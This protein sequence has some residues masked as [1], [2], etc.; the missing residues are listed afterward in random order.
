MRSRSRPS[1]VEIHTI[2]S[3]VGFTPNIPT[4]INSSRDVAKL[5]KHLG[6]IKAML[7]AITASWC[8]ACHQISDKLNKILND[9]NNV[10]PA[11]RLDY[12]NLP[13]LNKIMKTP[14]GADAYP[15][16]SISDNQGNSLYKPKTVEEAG[17]IIS[18]R[19]PIPSM[20]QSV[21][22]PEQEAAEEA[23]EEKIASQMASLSVP[24]NLPTLMKSASAK[25]Q[26]M[27]SIMQMESAGLPKNQSTQSNPRSPINSQSQQSRQSNPIQSVIPGVGKLPSV[28]AMSTATPP[29]QS[30]DQMGQSSVRTP[31][32]IQ[33][34]GSLYAS[35]ASTA[36]QLAPPAVLL[37]IAAAT[38]KK[39]KGNKKR[40]SRR[41][42][43]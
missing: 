25:S 2:Q 42:R 23:E 16:L 36:Y 5:E 6:Q 19:I 11:Y 26:T 12:T 20:K 14:V 22:T 37:G 7:I 9:P 4:T 28:A 8:G 13:K 1:R 27:N 17:D 35:L 3:N 24:E 38:L 18:G 33:A 43:L 30:M 15:E 10:M 32:Q 21:K 29:P 31:S 40:Q 41:R 34:G 39:R